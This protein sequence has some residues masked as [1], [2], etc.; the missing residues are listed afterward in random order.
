MQSNINY[1]IRVSIS[2]EA[3]QSKDIANAVIGSSNNE[4]NKEIKRA[5]GI[6]SKIC[7]KEEELS[8]SEFAE[9]ITSGHT[10]CNLFSGFPDA[11]GMTT[12]RRKDGYFTLS[13]KCDRFFVGAQMVCVDIDKTSYTSIAS[14]IDSLLYTPT[15]YHTSF[16]NMTY[17][18]DGTCKGLRFRLIYVFD[19]LITT[20]EEFKSITESLFEDIEKMTGEEIEDKCSSRPSQYFN[21]TCKTNPALNVEYGVSGYIYS[22]EEIGYKEVETEV[23]SGI[24]QDV[25][26][27]EP[28]KYL[29]RNIAEMD[30]DSFMSINK[31][32][33]KYTYRPEKSEWI[34]GKWQKIDDNYFSLYYNVNTLKDG[35]NR[36]KRIFQRMCLRRI[37]NPEIKIDDLVYCAWVDI[38]TFCDNSDG[39]FD[40]EYLKRN[41]TNAYSLTIEEIEQRYSDNINYLKSKAP[42]RG[43]IYKTGLTVGE[44][45]KLASEILE[46]LI[47]E[48][49]DPELNVKENLKQLQD[50]G[51]KV[52]RAYLYKFCKRFS[53][54]TSP[55][56]LSD[57][58]LLKL[59]NPELSLR[60]NM[61]YIEENFG[62][63]VKKCQLE[64]I[65]KIVS[66]K[67]YKNIDITNK[68]NKEKEDKVRTTTFYHRVDKIDSFK[69]PFSLIDSNKFKPQFNYGISG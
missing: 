66:N 68:N 10:F 32:R 26:P 44:R 16:S 31:H 49:Y 29:L 27:I 11:E 19:S 58:D 8:V 38:N 12:Y 41:A 67:E 13:A 2:K 55:N 24:E 18:E 20:K 46:G 57:S 42:K 9:K 25:I 3:Y 21:G 47:K 52:S 6:T 51:I 35:E 33:F 7:F 56:K 50:S 22:K 60:K 23:E 1:K 48:N 64:K 45:D 39:V 30:F 65:A 43:I 34:D 37:I 40:T 69:S 5:N 61:V 63:K 28:S 4:K 36:R 59:Y 15:I 54:A 62:F 14:F 17:R 53:L